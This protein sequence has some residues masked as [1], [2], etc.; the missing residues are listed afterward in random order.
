MMEADGIRGEVFGRPKHF[1]SIYKKMK[2][3]GKS[4]DQI[5]DITALRVIVGTSRNVIPFWARFT[6][7]GSPCRADKGLYR[8]SQAEQISVPAYHGDDAVRSAF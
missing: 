4:L 5:Y 3:K 2:N 1:Y 7:S 8:Q 6:K